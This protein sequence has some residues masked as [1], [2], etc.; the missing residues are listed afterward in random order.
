MT[1]QHSTSGRRATKD[2]NHTRRLK[3]RKG[4]YAR[5]IKDRHHIA[6]N[7]TVFSPVPWINIQG[8]WLEAAGFEINAPIKV[9]VS[10]GRLVLTTA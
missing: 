1:Q 7:H 10:L 5:I 6:F 3:V 9:E 2:K 8:Q 4:Y